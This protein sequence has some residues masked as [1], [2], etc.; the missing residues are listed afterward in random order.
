[1]AAGVAW[2][3]Q[4]LMSLY[5]IYLLSYQSKIYQ[6]YNMSVWL[7]KEGSLYGVCMFMVR[8]ISDGRINNVMKVGAAGVASRYNDSVAS[9]RHFHRDNVGSVSHRAQ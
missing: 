1:M 4:V 6:T 9:K 3:G 2:R 5:A 7:V 8:K